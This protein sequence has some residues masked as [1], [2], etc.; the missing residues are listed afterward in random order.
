MTEE[1]P[2][3]IV[4]G[5]AGGVGRA[6]VDALRRQG[7]II[8]AVDVSAD[9]EDLEAA[10]RSPIV[11]VR[12]DARS[13]GSA[14]QV[15]R[16]VRD[17]FGRLDVLVNNAGRFLRKPIL[18]TSDAE[19]DDLI[20][21]NARSAFSFTREAMPLLR[22]SKGCIVNVASTS[23]LIGVAEQPVYAMTKGAIVQLTR[24]QAIEQA[25]HGV[26]VNAVAPGAIDTD[27]TA[28]SRAA[29]PHPEASAR[30]SLA[31]H[32]IGRLSTPE[33]VA[34]AITFL[35]SGAASGITGAVLNV[36]GGYLAQ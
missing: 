1:S 7:H 36:D 34:D 25:A 30:I 9:V 8:L 22:S 27:F 17:R 11:S 14:E 10:G 32:P 23:G 35:A 18:D 21:I 29:D 33:E 16:L 26:R 6:T 20:Q 2:V 24:Q 15:V 13:P 5:A 28:E 31:R 3:A 12:L 4:T 19:F